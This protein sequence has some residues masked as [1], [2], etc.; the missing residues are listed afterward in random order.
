M[1]HQRRFGIERIV[2]L[3]DHDQIET[4]KRSAISGIFVD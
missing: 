4:Y 3:S 1:K 2:T